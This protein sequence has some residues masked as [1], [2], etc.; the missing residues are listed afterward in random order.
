MSV[1]GHSRRFWHVRAM[2]G[3]GNLGNA[4]CLVLPIEG[5]GLDVIQAQKTGASNYAV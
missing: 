4:G 1:V 2:S 5:I 3:R